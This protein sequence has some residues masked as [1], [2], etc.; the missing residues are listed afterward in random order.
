MSAMLAELMSQEY[1]KIHSGSEDQILAMMQNWS[2]MWDVT[3]ERIELLT[4]Y[5]SGLSSSSKVAVEEML[6][7]ASAGDRLWM[8]KAE[9]YSA[10]AEIQKLKRKPSDSDLKKT[11]SM[12][13][14]SS[15]ADRVDHRE[16]V[17][18]TIKLLRAMIDMQ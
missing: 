1:K 3:S 5:F 9:Y 13:I 7:L 6:T 11:L 15:K 10:L 18:E 17:K 12:V 4:E 14:E 8:C 16:W 2:G